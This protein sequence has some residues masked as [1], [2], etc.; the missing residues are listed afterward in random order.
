MF[1]L[2]EMMAQ[3]IQTVAQTSRELQMFK[4]EMRDFKEEMLAFKDEMRDFKEEMLAFKDEMRDFKEEMRLSNRQ[5]NRRWGELANKMGTMA[6]DLIA[7]GIPRIL[8]TVVDCPEEA[9]ES[10]AV[11]VRRRD[12]ETG[13][14]REFDV[15][16]ACGEYVLVNE[17]KSTLRSEDI[18]AFADRLPGVRRFFPEYEDRKFIGAIGSLYVD[19]ALVRRGEKLGLIVLGFGEEVV[20]VLNSP[21]FT[22]R[23]F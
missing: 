18:R 11:R 22:P 17:T 14:M 7:P 10:M 13:A 21:G 8:R 19:E 20:T 23:A 15:V 5:M 16:A 9:I 2:E 6:E 3:L 12:A 1:N 4:D